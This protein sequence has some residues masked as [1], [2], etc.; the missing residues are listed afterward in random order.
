ME[1]TV[2]G[3]RKHLSILAN[4]LNR[5]RFHV[6]VACAAERDRRFLDDVRQMKAC[7]A[8]V[9][10]LPM[11]REIAPRRD[12]VCL[13]KLC[14][15]MARRKYDIVHTHSSKAG[16]L[17]RLAAKIMRVPVIVHTPHTFAFLFKDHT[18]R[19]LKTGF[20]ELER[21]LG[22]FTD[23]LIAVSPSEKRSILQSKVISA[24]K[25]EVINN[26]VNVA[27][28]SQNGFIPA[29]VKKELN[30]PLDSYIIGTVGLLNVAKGQKYLILAGAEALK[31][32]PNL[33][34]LIVGSG[35]LEEELKALSRQ[36]Q[37]SSQVIFTGYR[38][39][40]ARMLSVMDIFVLP[41][42]WEAMPFAVLEAMAAGKPI[43]STDVDGARD[44]VIHG[45]TG[46][47]VPIGDK[48]AIAEAIV[49]LWQ[50]RSKAQRMGQMG[51]QRARSLFNI[52][53]MVRQTERLYLDLAA[54]KGLL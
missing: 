8:R 5:D 39:D 48:Q 19:L 15:L 18:T 12:V 1:C 49:R 52:D 27:E 44:A 45:E 10:L 11:T 7:G 41:S 43:I 14:H 35:E 36:Q 26:A 54:T 38:S 37:I 34:I 31:R 53:R 3:T 32:I 20:L 22:R 25:I 40:V 42:L 23:K 46:L 21:F 16:V 28:L 29:E 17:G 30:L 51:Q 4:H 47:L 13:C 24:E 9:F 50:N 33:R 6:S 2:G